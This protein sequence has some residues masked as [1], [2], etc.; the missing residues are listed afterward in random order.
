MGAA[1]ERHAMCESAFN[2]L[3]HVSSGPDARIYSNKKARRPQFTF[4][5]I[6]MYEYFQL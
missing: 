3:Y 2:L 6:I 4:L 5:F 1:W